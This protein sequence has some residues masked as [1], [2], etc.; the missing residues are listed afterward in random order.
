MTRP[1][2]ADDPTRDAPPPEPPDDEPRALA[3]LLGGATIVLPRGVEVSL[4]R[5]RSSGLP[6]E[7]TAASR[8]HATL[9]W[10]GGDEVLLIDAGSKN[11]TYVDGTRV[12]GTLALRSGA[13]IAIGRARVIIAVIPRAGVG[14]DSSA[15]PAIDDALLLARDPAMLRVVAL[16]ERAA[17]SDVPVLIVGE[18]GVGKEVIAR[19]VHARSRRSAAPFVAVDCASI[20]ETLAESL[21][22]GHERGA[23]TG[24]HA[25]HIGYFEAANGGTLFLDE[26]GELPLATQTRLLRVLQ[27]RVVQRVGG[28]EMLPVDVRIVAATNRDVDAAITAGTLRKDLLYRL[29]VVRL[30]VPPLRA[31][32]DDILPLAERFARVAAEGEPVR[33]AA[34]A[35]AALRAYGWPGNARELQNVVSRAVA[36][37]SGA[38]VHARDLEPMSRASSETRGALRDHVG[39]VERATIVTA[40]EA[41]GGNQVRTAARLGVSR[42]AL[43][44]KMERYG[45]KEPPKPRGGASEA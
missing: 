37:G 45:L 32:P 9:R 7:D 20:P 26:L 13:E 27:E 21:L 31:R 23:F 43:I 6:L 41:C 19:R 44:Y 22:F 10:D 34:D 12:E 40:L 42:R 29:D 3:A 28:T 38:V 1:P 11:G 18:T 2:T 14:A 15:T 4:G 17:R 35:V 30:T 36:L 24:A 8:L 5:S 39:D 33:F 16:A 25:K